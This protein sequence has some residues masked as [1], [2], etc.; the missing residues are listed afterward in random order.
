MSNFKKI[1]ISLLIVTII[2]IINT[3]SVHAMPSLSNEKQISVGF[4]NTASNTYKLTGS[5]WLYCLDHGAHLSSYD[6]NIY[7]VKY[8]V[9]IVG[10]EAK[11]GSKSEKSKYNAGLAYILSKGGGYGSS[12]KNTTSTQ[13]ALWWYWNSWLKEVGSKLGIGY[14]TYKN[15]GSG[16]H[17]NIAKSAE[18]YANNYSDSSASGGVSISGSTSIS[19]NTKGYASYK[20]TYTGSIKSIE[21]TYSDDS[22]ETI[23]SKSSNVKFYKNIKSDETLEDELKITQIESGKTFYILNEN[24]SKTIKNFKINVSRTVSNVYTATIYIMKSNTGSQRLLAC[25]HGKK[26]KTY[27]DSKTVKVGEVGDLTITKIGEYNDGGER[28]EDKLSGVQFKIYNETTNQWVKVSGDKTEYLDNTESNFKNNATIFETKNG[29]IKVNDLKSGLYRII[30]I[31]V[32]DNKA[33]TTKIKSTTVGSVE[34]KEYYGTRYST[35]KD[36]SIS[37]GSSVG[38]KIVDEKQSGELTIIKVGP[39]VD[40]VDKIDDIDDSETDEDDNESEGVDYSG[41][42]D[43][44]NETATGRDQTEGGLAIEEGEGNSMVTLA[45]AKM[46]IYLVEGAED[47]TKGWV[48]KQDSGISYTNDNSDENTVFTTGN[49]GEIKLEG[50]KYGKYAIY[51]TQSPSEK[52]F[53]LDGQDGYEAD[54]ISKENHWVYLG[55]VEVG[56]SNG[57]VTF[58]AIN[59]ITVGDLTIEKSDETYKDLKLSGVNIKLYS[60]K[61]NAWI[62]KNAN[63]EFIYDSQKT[64]SDATSFETDKDGKIFLEKIKFGTYKVYETKAAIGYDITKQKGYETDETSKENHWVYLGETTIDEEHDDVKYEV[65]NKKV[66]DKIE[67]FVWVDKPDTKA[68]VMDNIYTTES[69][70]ILKEGLQ[71]YLR[72]NDKILAST[73]TDSKG[74]YEFTKKDD[75][76]DIYYWDLANCYIA[77]IYDNKEYVCVDT[78]VGENSNVNSKAQE[79]EMLLDE[80]DDRK[81]TG[82]EGNLHGEAVTYKA[83][84]SEWT[85]EEILNNKDILTA[86]YNENEYTIKNIN[87]GIIEKIKPEFSTEE[88]IAYIKVKMKGYTYTYKYGGTAKVVSSVVPTVNE[89]NSSRTFTGSIYPSD[90][91]YNEV[92]SAADDKLQVYVVYRIDVTNNETSNIDNLYVEQKMYLASLQNS[93]DTERYELCTTENNTDNSEFALWSTTATNTT[94]EEAKYGIAS[95]DIKN[96]SSVFKDGI[97]SQDTVTSYI[98][99]KMKDEALKKILTGGL[100]YEDIEKAPT[101]VKVT[102]YH[103]YLRTDNVWVENDSVKSYAEAKRNDYEA[104]NSKNKKYYVHRSLDNSKVTS[105]LYL[106]L[107]LGSPRTISGTIFEDNGNKNGDGDILGNGIL[108]DEE[109]NRVADV[110][111]ELLNE[112]MEVASLYKVSVDGHIIYENENNMPK[113][114]TNTDEC[115]DYIFEGVV[116]GNYYIRFTYGNGEQRMIDSNGKEI[117]RIYANNYKSTII[118]TASDGAGEIIK[119]A[120]EA[121]KEQI[122]NAEQGV[123]NGDENSKK[124]IQWYK[125]LNNSGKG[126]STGVDDLNQRNAFNEY[127]YKADG[128]AINGQ[129]NNV[130]QFN[131]GILKAD[132]NAMTPITGISIENDQ[133]DVSDSGDEHKTAYNAFNFGII[134]TPEIK[135]TTDLVVTNIN[136]TNQVGSTVISD[137]PKTSKNQYLSDLDKN[138]VDGSK[139]AK[140][141]IDPTLI[142]GSSL[143]PTYKI[144]ITNESENDYIESDESEYKG[145]YYRY[146]DKQTGNAK[147]KAT[148]IKEVRNYIDEKYDQNSIKL[149]NEGTTSGNILIT[150]ISGESNEKYLNITGWSENLII[151]NSET[152]EYKVSALVSANDDT[153]FKNSVQIHTLSLD[154]MTTLK[155]SFKWAKA[156]TKIVITPQTGSNKDITYWIV[157]AVA[158]AVLAIGII[159]IKK[160]VID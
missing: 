88:T 87:L 127:S 136:F 75:G 96:S 159:I 20:A 55:T 29:V 138:S 99:F 34:E 126:F 31:S 80:L 144:T 17:N 58:K 91:A 43:N 24:Q 37:V 5:K 30:E 156:E 36:V 10:N 41:N 65:D 1:I 51:E 83:N 44:I 56:Y 4:S 148:S 131:N 117:T 108:D 71:V 100:K 33:Y 66:V 149:V 153:Q 76:S 60:V 89:Q 64:S 129:G 97:N 62:V 7:T 152:V 46:K 48:K 114:I 116:P 79:Y 140:I 92:N 123:L 84:K 110:R 98:Q 21:I 94:S 118:N 50:I 119:N 32:G 160:K 72:Q 135:V 54:S 70:D 90:V 93:Y 133:K 3:S 74:H 38:V 22:K 2:C 40:T 137:N 122:A 77:F 113:A 57:S 105:A 145:Y 120:M 47:G 14:S 85:Y 6:H 19:F 103:E 18:N 11:C 115:G 45:G 12:K 25:K 104:K 142:Y 59:K 27:T 8:T 154:K 112:N 86:Y 9:K 15:T 124:L 16:S 23:T 109:K 134:T 157:G 35:I 139:Y 128:T 26:A 150:P 130:E 143:T 68:N 147:L 78:F 111:V 13:N 49:D 102:V 155:Q 39:K 132:I 63:G 95:Y 61:K 107:K 158:L 67:G 146:G 82:T 106:K 28:I 73:K 81:L 101:T 69:N 53:S 42:I 125:Y 121:T 141:E 52:W 151:G